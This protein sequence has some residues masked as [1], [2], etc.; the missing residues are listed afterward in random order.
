MILSAFLILFLLTFINSEN[1]LSVT[2]KKI[3]L[4]QKFINCRVE[5]NLLLQ[6]PCQIKWKVKRIKDKRLD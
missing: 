1:P 6:G 3:S 4:K 2:K 5:A